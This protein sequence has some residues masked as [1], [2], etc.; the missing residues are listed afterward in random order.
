MDTLWKIVIRYSPEFKA[1]QHDVPEFLEV[2]FNKI[3]YGFTDAQQ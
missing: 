2:F 1:G 3:L